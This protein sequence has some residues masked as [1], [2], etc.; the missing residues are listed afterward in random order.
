M[1]IIQANGISNINELKNSS[2]WYWGTDYT[3]GDLY[4]AEELFRDEHE[5][6]SNR[7]IF[8]HFPEGRTAEP[9]KA[10]A[11]QYFG[12]P[13]FDQEQV[14]LLMVDFPAEKILILRWNP[15]ADIVDHVTE[16]PLSSAIDCY[17]LSLYAGKE[18]MLLRQGGSEPLQII[19]PEKAQFSIGERE[20]FVFRDGDRLYFSRWEEDPDYREEVV[21]R[22]FPTG[23]ILEVLPG[24]LQEF[25]SGQYWLLR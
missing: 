4:E 16:I 10:T 22:Q 15:V 5:I 9:I 11:G 14:Y 2:G 7:L 19:W 21:I 20:S 24:V 1:K 6:R 23:E 18:L 8:L 17:N 3:D 25:P 12:K 13:V